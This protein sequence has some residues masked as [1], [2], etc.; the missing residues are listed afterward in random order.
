[1]LINENYLFHIL[2]QLYKVWYRGYMDKHENCINKDSFVNTGYFVVNFV[3]RL[4][5][6]LYW[7]GEE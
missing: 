1:M 2:N 6:I 3:V 5:F 7:Y 4:Q